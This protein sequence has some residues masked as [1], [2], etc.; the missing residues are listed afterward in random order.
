CLLFPRVI[1][2]DA[3]PLLH[4]PQVLQSQVVFNAGPYC[5][6]VA[7]KVLE[8]IVVG[9]FFEQPVCHG[10]PFSVSHAQ[11]FLRATNRSELGLWDSTG[12]HRFEPIT[13][14]TACPARLAASECGMWISDRRTALP[15]RLEL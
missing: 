6:L 2:E 1:I 12:H 11:T 3:V 15:G 9:L 14:G 4:R 13:S 10:R 5:P 7:E 8:R